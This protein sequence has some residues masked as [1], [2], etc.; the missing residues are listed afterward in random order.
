MKV[1]SI[2]IICL[3]M[4]AAGIYG[5]SV[6]KSGSIVLD[7]TWDTDTVI[8]T[9][10]VSIADTATLTIEPG[11][12][13]E[14]Q[15]RYE[16]NVY[17]R[18]LAVGTEQD[19]IIFTS[20]DTNAGWMGI[21][22][23]SREA[24]LI[25]YAVIEYGKA[26][27]QTTLSGGAVRF[28]LSSGMEISHCRISNNRANY[29]GGAIYCAYSSPTIVNN[30]I[31]ANRVT[32]YGAKGG[33][34]ACCYHSQPFIEGN[35][36]SNNFSYVY[37]GGVFCEDSSCPVI[38]YNEISGNGANYGSGIYCHLDAEPY[39]KGNRIIN[40]HDNEYYA[41]G[42]GIY[43]DSASPVIDSNLIAGNEV[44]ALGSG[45]LGNGAGIYLV[46]SRAV[47]C[48]N[49]ISDNIARKG[50]GIHCY[51]STTALITNNTISGNTAWVGG[52]I[53]CFVNSNP[54]IEKN[55]INA[56]SATGNSANGAGILCLNGSNP[57]IVN[58]IITDNSAWGTNGYGGG[59]YCGQSSEPVISNN[60][61]ARDSARSYGGAI[62]CNSSCGPLIVGNTMVHNY[63]RNGRAVYLRYN[64]GSR[65]INNIIWFQSGLSIGMIDTSSKPVIQYC[66]IQYGL[67]SMTSQGA[68][69]GDY[70]NNV[71]SYPEFTD[72]TM[73]DF[74]L[75]DVSPCI[76]AGTPDTT[77]LELPD[78][79]LAGNSRISSN[80]VDIGAYEYQGPVSLEVKLPAMPNKT[81][82][83]SLPNPFHTAARISFSLPAKR[84]AALRVYNLKGQV[85]KNLLDYNPGAGKHEVI[86]NPR[87]LP[88]GIYCIVLETGKSRITKRIAFLK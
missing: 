27:D 67:D 28:M 62:Y 59:V 39:I 36:I 75:L 70:S 2:L 19:S 85:V 45:A 54:V 24:S 17:G 65:I 5:T 53:Y 35:I 60:L 46:Y 55:T 14:F 13:V 40:N 61:F 43:C 42:A 11:T 87:D 6:N 79:D 4:L 10:T 16:L 26:V 86:F 33:G 64:S 68:W 71:E 8:I 73:G 1:S 22:F 41:E 69:V 29:R 20:L 84:F 9:G 74:S 47:I 18:I 56:N 58:N 83:K 66:N 72:T 81:A 21:D 57:L 51:G 3:G 52:G 12:Y 48:S 34:I 77:G 44:R 63:G 88:C 38:A 37:G 7:E 76:N 49:T 82:L 30:T 23:R 31:D 15:G 80:R 32:E 78:Q 50:G 25:S